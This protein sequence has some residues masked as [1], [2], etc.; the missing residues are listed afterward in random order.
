MREDTHAT[1]LGAPTLAE[2]AKAVDVV[3]EDIIEKVL[4]YTQVDEEV[5]AQKKEI[6]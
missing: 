1:P 5:N 6:I 3:V 2:L 4:K